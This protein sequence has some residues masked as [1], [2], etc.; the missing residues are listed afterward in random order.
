MPKKTEISDLKKASARG[1]AKAAKNLGVLYEVGLE[2]EAD[3]LVAVEQFKKAADLGDEGALQSLSRLYKDGPEKVRDAKALKE[4]SDK[5][6]DLGY[7]SDKE[8]RDRL[9]QKSGLTKRVLVVDD[10]PAI[11]EMVARVLG[12]NKNIKVEVASDGIAGV[13]KLVDL[14]GADLVVCDYKMPKMNG[15]EFVKILREQLSFNVPVMIMSG[16]SD[17]DGNKEKF[18]DLNVIEILAKP[19][20]INTI[21]DIVQSVLFK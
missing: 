17:L 10:D 4:V 5:L 16:V 13:K 12:K 19:V 1:D 18:K 15:F 20:K 14:K 7:K 3:P 6:L 11:C 9:T 8:L 21:R 2:V